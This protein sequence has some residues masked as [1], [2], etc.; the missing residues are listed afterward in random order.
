[1]L[2][3]LLSGVAKSRY[4]RLPID[5]NDK[6]NWQ[7]VAT[8]FKE[9]FA[10]ELATHT[11]L[12]NFRHIKQDDQENVTLSAVGVENLVSQAHP[13]RSSTDLEALKMKYFLTCI[14]PSIR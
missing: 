10:T 12:E 13:K 2:P 8:K 6:T 11:V 1:M 14:T 9:I 4:D 3:L 7:R 5:D